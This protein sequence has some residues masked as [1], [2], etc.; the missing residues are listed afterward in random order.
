MANSMYA[1]FCCVAMLLF[2]MVIPALLFLK[3]NYFGYLMHKFAMM[4]L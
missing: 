4:S 3:T 2:Q 1:E